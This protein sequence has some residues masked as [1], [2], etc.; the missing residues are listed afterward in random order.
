MCVARLYL[1]DNFATSAALAEVVALLSAALVLNVNIL[2]AEKGRIHVRYTAFSDGR[3]MSFM[4]EKCPGKRST[5]VS[6]DGRILQCWSFEIS[7]AAR[8]R[9]VS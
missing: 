4:T 3:E 5:F 9:A 7:R 1:V 8:R 6:D 2:A